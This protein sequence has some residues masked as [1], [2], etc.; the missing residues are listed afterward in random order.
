MKWAMLRL[1]IRRLMLIVAGLAVIFGFAAWMIR[2]TGRSNRFGQLA[3]Q[4]AQEYYLHR[5]HIDSHPTLAA[6]LE[7]AGMSPQP[8]RSSSAGPCGD[9]ADA[10]TTGP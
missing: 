4:H 1:T 5:A 7:K 9:S 2:M 8:P 6:P 3:N 10:T